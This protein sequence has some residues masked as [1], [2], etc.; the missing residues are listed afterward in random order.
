MVRI[1]SAHTLSSVEYVPKIVDRWVENGLDLIKS[2]S[3]D[4]DPMAL[5]AVR[6]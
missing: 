6:A 3:L 1:R 5:P 4:L 2:G